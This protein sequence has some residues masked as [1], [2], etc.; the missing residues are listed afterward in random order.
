MVKFKIKVINSDTFQNYFSVNS[1]VKYKLCF[2]DL[3]KFQKFPG[4]FVACLFWNIFTKSNFI[5]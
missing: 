2:N 5:E 4:G 1:H 3:C